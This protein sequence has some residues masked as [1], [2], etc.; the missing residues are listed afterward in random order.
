MPNECAVSSCSNNARKTG[1]SI[2]YYQFPKRTEIR[3]QWIVACKRGDSQFNPDTSRVCSEH[4]C[5]ADYVRNLKA[6]LLG[7]VPNRLILKEEAVPHRNLPQSLIN[8]H[9]TADSTDCA[10]S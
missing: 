7:Y 8:Q 5:D 6:E 4:F 3:K 9:A 10:E 2:S 1:K